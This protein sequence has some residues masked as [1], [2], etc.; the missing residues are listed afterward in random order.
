MK[1]YITGTSRGI[2]KIFFSY[3]LKKGWQVIS[4]DR[5]HKIDDII[6]MSQDCDLFINNA[7]DK[8]LQL[9]LLKRFRG[10][11]M[12]ICGSVVTDFPDADLPEY[13][14]HKTDL[15]QYFKEN[16]PKNS[17]LLK[18]SNESYNN[19]QLLIDSIE[20]WIQHPEVNVISFISGEPNR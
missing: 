9:E 3:F 12:V 11:S 13:T 16:A 1:C 8:D 20:F 19:P 17:L 2:G 6:S 5:S 4:F 10:K 18:I 15:E 14:K 7:Y